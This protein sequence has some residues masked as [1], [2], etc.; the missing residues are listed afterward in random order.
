MGSKGSPASEPKSRAAGTKK[1]APRAC[2][3]CRTR[4][5]RCDVT[6]SQSRCTNC[7]LDNKKCV[8]PVSKRR[9]VGDRI[10]SSAFFDGK[11][12]NSQSPICDAIIDFGDIGHPTPE[13]KAFEGTNPVSED[14]SRDVFNAAGAGFVIHEQ[15]NLFGP[16]D[17]GS[18]SVT[19][20]QDFQSD[21]GASYP[22]P[23]QSIQGDARPLPSWPPYIACPS[24]GVSPED[25]EYLRSRG[26]FEI[27][28][29]PTRDLLLQAYTR[30]VHPFSPMLDLQGILTAISSNGSKGT[31]SLL[32]FQSLLF[33][34][35]AFVGTG[36]GQG[37]RKATRKI[38]YER[39]RLLHDFNVESDRLAVVQAA[40]LL[41]FWD[42]DSEQVRDSYYWVGIASLH[43]NTVGLNL[44][45]EASS[46]DPHRQRSLKLT[47]W[48]L[49]IRDRLIAVAMRR[50]VQNVAFKIEVSML[51]MDDFEL[52]PLLEALQDTC[53]ISDV[54]MAELETLAS[55]CIALAQLSDY[56]DRILAVEYSTQRAPGA[57]GGHAAASLVPNPRGFRCSEMAS[58]GQELRNWYGYLPME[59]QLVDNDA[60]RSSEHHVVRVH[61]A[62]LA[63]YYSMTLMTLYRPL[64]TLPLSGTNGPE[65]RTTSIKMVF[66]ST[67][68]ITN[69]FSSLY[70]SHMIDFL[71]DTAIAVLEPAVVT[72]L[73]YSMSEVPKVRATSFQ[74]FYLCWRIL[75]Q[76]GKSYYLA[77]TTISMLNAATQRLKTHMDSTAPKL[78]VYSQLIQNLCARR[79]HHA[80]RSPFA[81]PF[82]EVVGDIKGN[83]VA[84]TPDEDTSVNSSDGAPGLCDVFDSSE[85]YSLPE[86]DLGLD[87]GIFDQLV[88]WDSVEDG[89]VS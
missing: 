6:R 27:P 89:M 30:W 34:A 54:G 17:I 28:D 8:V 82:V 80:S 32:V 88:C 75:L 29:P 66:Q 50:P 85:D 12:L 25:S 40:I 79:S 43:A 68:A 76:F 64:L 49:L 37:A 33:A 69:I 52:C 31:V 10:L 41:S 13:E 74:K 83:T 22:S 72:H 67:M 81:V 58:C 35:T 21:M 65:L 7:K 63:G 36:L 55:S 60:S 42:G 16:M 15:F 3:A 62:L 2:E 20:L 84:S 14:A 46:D 11:D 57:H 4:K 71:P 9:H 77:D 26:A 51:Q 18:T 53:L 24:K 23:T 86:T 56:I 61:R 38:F 45:P 87:T 44:G 73:L 48:S 47:W 1:R 59:I 78:T 5:V 19:G 70:A 39:A